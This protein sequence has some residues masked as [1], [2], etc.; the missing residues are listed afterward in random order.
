MNILIAYPGVIPA[1]QYGGTERVIWYLGNELHT[2]GH[3][4]T[5]LVDRG[6]TCPFGNVIYFDPGKSLADH[7]PANVDIVHFNFIPESAVHKPYVVTQ[8]G[9]LDPHG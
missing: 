6:S 7:I 9:N 1:L 5:Y 3:S 8:H 4:V 2:L